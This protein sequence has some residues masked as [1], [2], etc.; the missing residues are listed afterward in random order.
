MI[1]HAGNW[2]ILLS[3]EFRSNRGNET[4]VFAN[5]ARWKNADR[6][7]SRQTSI[8]FCHQVGFIRTILTSFSRPTFHMRKKSYITLSRLLYDPITRNF[9]VRN[10]VVG[11]FVVGNFVVGNFVVGNFVVGN[12][13]VGNF[14]VGNFVVGNFVVRNFVV[15]NFVVGNF[16]V[17]NFVVR[18]FVVRNFVV[19]NFVVGNYVL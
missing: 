13:V 3:V 16:V 11:N 7:S 4:W 19:R 10:F 18:K 9:F 2:L 5:T 14:V 6:A 1:V 17:R 8:K 12:F 15:G